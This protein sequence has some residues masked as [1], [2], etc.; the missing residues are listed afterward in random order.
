MA[1]RSKH[2]TTTG[3]SPYVL[4][5]GLE[6]CTKLPDLRRKAPITDE[7]EVRK[8]TGKKQNR[9]KVVCVQQKE[10]KGQRN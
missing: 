7:E 8:N 4:M 5:F 9:R 3:V 2:Q 10:R 6:K 1:Y